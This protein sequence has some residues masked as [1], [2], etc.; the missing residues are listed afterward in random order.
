MFTRYSTV[1]SIVVFW[2]MLEYFC[3]SYLMRIDVFS[4]QYRCPDCCTVLLGKVFLHVFV[5]VTYFTILSAVFSFLVVGLVLQRGCVY[6]LLGV[7]TVR[8]FVLYCFCPPCCDHCYPKAWTGFTGNSMK[9]SII[10]VT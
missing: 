7:D 1:S 5:V 4:T 3:F 10:G 8:Y 6:L 2:L 9:R